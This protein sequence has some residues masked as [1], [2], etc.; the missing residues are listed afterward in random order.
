MT[1]IPVTS[2]PPSARASELGQRLNAT[3][4]DYCRQHPG[5][6]ASDIRQAL[7]LARTRDGAAPQALFIALLAGVA[8][9]G[10]LT[11]FY[12]RGAPVE[13]GSPILMFVIGIAIL[14][15][16]AAAVLRNR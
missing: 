11:F 4:E 3:I 8:L 9:L 2:P 7:S 1:T 15:V 13:G 6:T 14:V 12:F 10:A 16:G 5:T